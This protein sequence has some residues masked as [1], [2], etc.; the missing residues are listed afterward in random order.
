MAEMMQAIVKAKAAPGIEIRQVPVP[1]VGATD[2][3]VRVRAASV[4]GTD[5]H[6]FNWDPWAQGRIKP[7]LV[8]GHEF[9]GVVERVGED[10]TT[11]KAGDFVSAEMHVACGKCLQCRTGQAH[12]C[13]RVKIIGVD[14]D[15]AFAEFVKIP[16]S[17]IWKLDQAIPEEWG[18]LMDPLGNAVHTVLAG[19]IATK[20]VAVIGCGPI[21]L[22]AIAV[23]KLC[24]A[25]EV[26]AV[27][28][29]PYRR[30]LATKMGAD[31]VLDPASEDA[32]GRICKLTGG[33]GVDVVLEMSG[34][35]DGIRIG[36]KALRTGG[37]V[38]LL[39]LPS[40][41]VTL[42]LADDVIFKGATVQGINGRKMFET[43]YQMEA[44]L[45][46]GK[47]DLDPVI[48]HHIPLRDFDRAMELLKT[49]EA[50]K[51]ILTPF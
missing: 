40:R 2:V 5:L 27:E 11:V 29:N 24:G 1:V 20:T 23:A 50:S 34:H 47:L 46:G 22:F 17:N 8:P 51:I 16:E 26:F 37:R 18:S 48:S 38:S 35:Q 21:G 13:Q 19:E 7:P 25:A 36:F 28:V 12:I 43:W 32:A 15:G 45:K 49:G 42:N 14:S 10:V 4:C 9:C 39:G 3:L 6:I 31:V 44:L 30:G 41:E 33:V